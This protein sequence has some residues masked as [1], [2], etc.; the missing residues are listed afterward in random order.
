MPPSVL[1]T[2]NANADVVEVDRRALVR[3]D[4]NPENLC[5]LTTADRHDSRWAKIRNVSSGGIGLVANR[6][7][8]QGSH[9]YIE[10]HNLAKGSAQMVRA[11]VKHS[12]QKEDG[13]WQIG[14]EF[15]EPLRDAEVHSML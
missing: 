11:Q 5:H 6:E 8:A 9:L 1:A 3:F 4:W 12:T 7:Y 2:T 10:L 13:S 14:C 15:L